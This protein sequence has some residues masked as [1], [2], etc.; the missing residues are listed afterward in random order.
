MV[1]VTAEQTKGYNEPVTDLLP[2]TSECR[3]QHVLYD[4][5]GDPSMS[6]SCQV[7]TMLRKEGSCHCPQGPGAGPR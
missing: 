7:G 1:H 5:Q 3:L 4:E 2:F 6:L